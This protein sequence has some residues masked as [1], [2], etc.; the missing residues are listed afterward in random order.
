MIKSVTV[1]NYL[2]E[3]IVLDLM[4]PEKSGFIV[5]SI[6]GLGP[7]KATINKTEMATGD[8]S[9]YN[10]A[11]MSSRNI[12]ISLEFMWAPTVEHVR[13]LSYK[14]F[15]I[16]KNLELVFETDNRIA[17]INGYVESNDPKI[18]SNRE[19]TDISIICPDPLFYS[20]GEDGT[21]VTVFSGIEAAFEF[22]F[23]NESLDEPLIE[24]G[25]IHSVRDKSIYYDG[26]SEIGIKITINATGKATDIRIYNTNT[27]ESMFIDTDKIEKITGEGLDAGDEITIVTVKSKKSI[28]LLRDGKRTNILNCLSKQN[29]WFTL[30]KGENIFAY[31][32]ETGAN[33]L[34]FKIENEVAYEGV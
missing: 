18:F 9:I 12:V 24:M 13:Q 21:N 33:N 11:R 6:T 1:K 32:A 30:S 22:P 14:Y 8:G 5:K 3:T 31:T 19:G 23:S 17:K 28:T 25:I 2:G 4:K 20:A 16:K 26:D 7:G 34:H 10:S 29:D 15:P 27:R